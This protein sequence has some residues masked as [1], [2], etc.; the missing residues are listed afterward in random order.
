MASRSQN[1]I[2]YQEGTILFFVFKISYIQFLL[3]A[4]LLIFRCWQLISSNEIN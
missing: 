1:D 2:L 4:V 3:S